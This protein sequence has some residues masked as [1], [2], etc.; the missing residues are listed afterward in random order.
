ANFI[1]INI[2]DSGFTAAEL[3]ERL[4]KYGILIRDCSSF[5]GLDEYYIRVAVRTRRE[6]EKFINSLRDI[7]N[8]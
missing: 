4:L 7:L 8:S 6:N 2:R 3:K 5:R 1:L